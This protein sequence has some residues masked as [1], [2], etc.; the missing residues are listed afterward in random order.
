[1]YDKLGQ[2][3]RDGGDQYSQYYGY[4]EHDDYSADILYHQEEEQNNQGQGKHQNTSLLI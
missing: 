3:H 2:F 1:M 4:Y